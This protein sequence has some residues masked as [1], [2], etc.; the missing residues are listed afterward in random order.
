MLSYSGC[1]NFKSHHII[2]MEKMKHY[3]YFE[4]GESVTHNVYYVEYGEN[5]N[6][7]HLL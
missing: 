1:V 4:S 7:L 3:I 2:F 6:I 5:V